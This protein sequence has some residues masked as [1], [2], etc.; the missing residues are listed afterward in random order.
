MCPHSYSTYVCVFSNLLLYLCPQFH[1]V[2]YTVLYRLL[3]QHRGPL[4]CLS[5]D[6]RYIERDRCVCV[7]V[8]VCVCMYSR[9]LCA[10]LRMLCR[11]ILLFHV[12]T[13][14][15][16]LSQAALSVS[17]SFLSAVR[18]I[19]LLCY[20]ATALDLP[21]SYSSIHSFLSAVPSIYMSPSSCYIS[22]SSLYSQRVLVLLQK[23]C[24]AAQRRTESTWFMVMILCIQRPHTALYL[25]S[26]YC[27]ISSI[28]A[29]LYMY[30]PLTCIYLSSSYCN[31]HSVL[32]LLCTYRPLILLHI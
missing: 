29:L 30:H 27:T 7:R 1:G 3:S 28:L 15:L 5:H 17:S 4:L 24:Y 2:L 20:C 14:C 32:I 16:S 23:Y 8:R 10:C 26:S 25:A 22:S 19:Y 6:R 12:L 31:G 13:F 9:S 18:S 21:S 11:G